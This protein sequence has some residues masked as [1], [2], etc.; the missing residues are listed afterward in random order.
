MVAHD[1]RLAGEVKLPVGAE[2][3]GRRILADRDL[4]GLS[5]HGPAG[6]QVGQGHSRPRAKR[7]QHGTDGCQ[8]KALVEFGILLRGCG[9][10]SAGTEDHVPDSVEGAIEDLGIPSVAKVKVALR[11]QVCYRGVWA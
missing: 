8:R 4:L 6:G 7:V 2:G 10:E 11:D 5:V 3:L 1:F 9:Q